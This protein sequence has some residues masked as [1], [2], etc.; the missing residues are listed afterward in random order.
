MI[1][2][3]GR[4]PALRSLRN[5]KPRERADGVCGAGACSITAATTAAGV[6]RAIS[7]VVEKML[8]LLLRQYY[9]CTVE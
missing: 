7:A 3:F 2:S 9:Y 8:L 6:A 5:E 4:E 1:S